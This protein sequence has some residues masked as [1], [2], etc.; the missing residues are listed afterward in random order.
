L[1]Y[2]FVCSERSLSNEMT[3]VL[4]DEDV[5][6][7]LVNG[8]EIK[9]SKI[10]WWIDRCLSEYDIS[11]YVVQGTNAIE[12]FYN[13]S[14]TNTD[15]SITEGFETER[16][17]FFY[18]VEPEAIYI[19]GNFDIKPTGKMYDCIRYQTFENDDFVIEKAT[20]KTLGNLTTQG[21]CFYRGDVDYKFNIENIKGFNNVVLSLDSFNGFAAK[22]QIGEHGGYIINKPYNIDITEYL[23]DGNN[24]VCITILGTNRNLLGPHHHVNGKNTFVG[25]DTY[26]GKKGFEDFVSLTPLGDITWT[27]D[28]SFI[29]FGCNKILINYY[30]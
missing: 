12:L 15:I 28:Y 19:R 16:N 13:I 24:E 10:D 14:A 7:I 6:K 3:M 1:K 4:E 26:A 21:L 20:S 22:W 17:R 27:S 2:E 25:P 5:Q 18:P 30:K 9:G 8:E 29:P 23:N 11:N